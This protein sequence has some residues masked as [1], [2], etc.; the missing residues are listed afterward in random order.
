MIRVNKWRWEMR[1]SDYEMQCKF[2]FDPQKWSVVIS[3]SF[4]FAS[5]VAVVGELLLQIVD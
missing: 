4:T 3:R 2:E 1:T 5:P